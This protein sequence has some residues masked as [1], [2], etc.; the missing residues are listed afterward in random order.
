MKLKPANE[1]C[2]S[3]QQPKRVEASTHCPTPQQ[4]KPEALKIKKK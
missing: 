1:K 3:Q 4:Q 2:K